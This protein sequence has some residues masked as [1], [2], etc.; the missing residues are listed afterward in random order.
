MLQDGLAKRAAPKGRPSARSDSRLSAR[1]SAEMGDDGLPFSVS[2]PKVFTD[3]NR[4]RFGSVAK[5]PDFHPPSPERPRAPPRSGR[6]VSGSENQQCDSRRIEYGR[7]VKMRLD[8]T[9]CR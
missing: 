9:H 7:F 6:A 1:R 2:A 8:F 4:F 3:I 5:D